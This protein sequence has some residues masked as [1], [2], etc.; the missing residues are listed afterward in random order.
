MAESDTDVFWTD[1]RKLEVVRGYRDEKLLKTDKYMMPD[2]PITEEK[3]E[4]WKIYR[5]ALRDI[6]T[7]ISLADIV[8]DITITIQG[9]IWPTPPSP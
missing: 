7:N 1:D 5:Q 3:R 8:I 4:E 9:D 2:F 6:T